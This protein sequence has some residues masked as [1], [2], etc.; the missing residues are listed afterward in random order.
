MKLLR[1]LLAI[2]ISL[3][4]ALPTA[5]VAQSIGVGLSI[6]H[7]S[8][9][10]GGVHLLARRT[11]PPFFQNSSIFPETL[12]FNA[13]G[14]SASARYSTTYATSHWL[15]TGT[16]YYVG[17]ATSGC[18]DA[19]TGLSL[20]QCF[21]TLQ[22]AVTTAAAGSVIQVA[23]GRYAPVNVTKNLS[24]VATNPG[25]V[26]V[27][28][29]LTNADVS[30]WGRSGTVNT[31][32]LTTSGSGGIVNGFVDLSNTYPASLGGS[33][34][35]A[36][37]EPDLANVQAAQGVG[38]AG[39]M[40]S[41]SAGVNS[42]LGAADGRDLTNLFNST[43]LAW[44]K[45]APSPLTVSAGVRL[46][47]KGIYWVGGQSRN[48]GVASGAV[49]TLVME[50]GGGLGGGSVEGHA[51]VGQADQVFEIYGKLVMK[52]AV[53]IGS[54][55]ENQDTI[56]WDSSVRGSGVLVDSFIG[57]AGKAGQPGGT[58]A[59]TF[60]S[61]YGVISVNT[62]TFDS[63]QDYADVAPVINGIFNGRHVGGRNSPGYVFG[64]ANTT[65]E[66]HVA[67]FQ[68]IDASVG[69]QYGVYN[70][71]A[72][73]DYDNST[74]PLVQRSCATGTYYSWQGLA[75]QT[76]DAITAQI[77]VDRPYVF[78]DA[79]CT[80]A[81]TGT[82]QNVLCIK[83]AAV[84]GQTYKPIV[85]TITYNEV[86]ALKSLNFGPASSGGTGT[87]N[88]AV[89]QLFGRNDPPGLTD[90]ILAV[91]STDLSFD[92][93]SAS[94]TLSGQIHTFGT[95]WTSG[96]A[97]Y[98]AVYISANV[99]ATKVDGT[100]KS[101]RTALRDA[102]TTAS[103]VAHVITL[104]NCDMYYFMWRNF[105]LMGGTTDARYTFEG[106]FYGFTQIRH[107]GNATY[108]NARKAE[109]QAACGC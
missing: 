44:A 9:R 82:G 36:S 52:D 40:F 103:T 58:Q 27:G 30:S 69:A 49:A 93:I 79:N 48:I 60:H 87:N 108:F 26:Y 98:N 11:P 18:S 38:R 78:T 41:Y 89:L 29:F 46:F 28:T 13:S 107:T 105:D 101:S 106:D 91:K 8:L 102:I 43:I 19:N 7:A 76:A 80:T 88:G 75:D 57:G 70:C 6:P 86:G 63:T 4:A 21:A 14:A 100:T 22:Q 20:A 37:G 45:G 3:T 90:N 25:K 85:G 1:G 95:A 55:I 34:M 17:Q 54:N 53:A 51:A 32:T 104:E 64:M 62:V 16:T 15:D 84:A 5:V 31:V 23:D 61:G 39:I 2:L 59:V 24:M 81:V 72:V 10:S 47:S 77:I 35:V 97:P 94:V 83:D 12:V 66:Y 67:D 109:V 42:I 68:M 65:A 56:D 99:P 50:G 92:V 96:T 71:G 74:A 73:F 33:P